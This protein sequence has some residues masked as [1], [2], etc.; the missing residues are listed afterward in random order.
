MVMNGVVS[1]KIGI[2]IRIVV[3]TS[4]LTQHVITVRKIHTVLYIS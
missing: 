4:S 2:F 3:R 1:Q